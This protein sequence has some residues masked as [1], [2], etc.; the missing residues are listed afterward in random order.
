MQKAG[1][2][3]SGDGKKPGQ[4]GKS[5]ENGTGGS[6]QGQGSEGSSEYGDAEQIARMAAQQAA[7][8]KQLQDLQNR[9][10]GTGMDNSK[11]LREIQQQMD[12][13]ETDLVNRRLTAQLLM[14]QQ[15]ILTRLLQAEK[16]LREQEQDDKRASNTAKEI[17][18]PIP[19]ELQRY[20]QNR[21]QLLELYR[22]IPPQLKPYYKHMVDEY[23]KNIGTR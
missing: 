9:L 13:N 18:R 11:E 3:K 17:S 2:Q 14:R 19:P 10:A 7:I 23:F 12:R 16:T 15:E 8:R 5:G 21:Q 4:E 20:M 6:G 22:T 1:G